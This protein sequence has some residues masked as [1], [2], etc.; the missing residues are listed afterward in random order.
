M[1]RK[2]DVDLTEAK[3]LAAQLARELRG[4]EILA[5]VGELGSGKTTFTQALAKQLGVKEKVL[6]PTFILLQEFEGKLKD[7]RK[8]V[9]SHLD[10]YRTDSFAEIIALGLTQT[11][12][13]DHTV[14]VIEWAD[15]IKNHLPPSTIYINLTRNV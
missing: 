13:Q 7:K 14:T 1:K 8:V 15:K 11:W 3:E 4:G 12:G 10:L 6:S 5:L 9:L 2:Y